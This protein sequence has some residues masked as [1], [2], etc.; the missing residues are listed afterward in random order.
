MELSAGIFQAQTRKKTQTFLTFPPTVHCAS[1]NDEE[2]VKTIRHGEKGNI[3]RMR[4]DYWNVNPT[5]REGYGQIHLRCQRQTSI[6][7]E[8]EVYA[9]LTSF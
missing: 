2:N 8:T 9:T 6:K 3:L 7:R 5:L 1:R 4:N